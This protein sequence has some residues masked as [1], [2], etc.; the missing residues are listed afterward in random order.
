MGS[1]RKDIL[2]PAATRIALAGAHRRDFAARFRQEA[3]SQYRWCDFGA[4]GRTDRKKDTRAAF[5]HFQM[6]ETDAAMRCFARV[7][8]T[9]P[10]YGPGDLQTIA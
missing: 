5:F 9:A 8:K 10:G 2:S 4:A 1:M 6:E 7:L 3:A